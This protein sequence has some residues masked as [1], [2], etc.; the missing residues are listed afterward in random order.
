MTIIAVVQSIIAALDEAQIPYMLTGSLAS[1]IYGRARSTQGID[2]VIAPGAAEL[3][4]F[5]ELLSPDRY[6][7]DLSQALEALRSESMFNVIELE[8]GWKI[9][10]IIRK[11]RAF[12]QEEFH[13]RQ[14]IS[15][16]QRPVFVAAAEDIII[17][18]LEWAKLSEPE[19]QLGDVAGILKL[20][21]QALDRSY[22]Q[23]WIAELGLEEQWA[24]AR[25]LAGVSG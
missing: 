4:R 25:R 22:L 6:F 16:D 23:T 21:C 19:R 7:R 20:D 9:D 17:S 24:S 3:H 18:K 10:L 14:Q 2:F 13:R 11:S 5:I 8:T 1:T 15:I 12:S